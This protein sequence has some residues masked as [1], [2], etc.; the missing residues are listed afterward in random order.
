M[1]YFGKWH[2][3]W[4]VHE[5]ELVSQPQ[6]MISEPK[7]NFSL[8]PSYSFYKSLYDKSLFLKPLLC[9][10][11]HK[12]TK[13]THFIFH[14]LHY[15]LSERQ[16]LIMSTISKRKLRKTITHIFGPIHI[17]RALKTASIVCTDEQGDLF[18][19]VGPHRN[20]C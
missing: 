9:Q 11:F 17:P 1:P 16:K 4:V 2:N 8:S 18:Y 5:T 14:R 3:M 15:F 13:T 19:C 6:R 7:T 10:L 20:R 12:E